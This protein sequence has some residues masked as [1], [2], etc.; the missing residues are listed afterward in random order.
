M[1]SFG[2]Y[3]LGFWLVL[4]LSR[5]AWSELEPSAGGG[6]NRFGDEGEG[7]NLVNGGD[8]EVRL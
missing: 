2:G 4:L 1:P 5:A 7:G 8:F 3:S 6:V